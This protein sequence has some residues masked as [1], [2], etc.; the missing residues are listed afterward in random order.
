MIDASESTY[1]DPMTTVV[2]NSPATQ[3]PT[4][5]LNDWSSKHALTGLLRFFKPFTKSSK[6]GMEIIGS[7]PRAEIGGSVRGDLQRRTRANRRASR[8]ATWV[9]SVSVPPLT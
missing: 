3:L 7:K 8:N 4:P 6:L 2:L 5:A 9:A 1:I